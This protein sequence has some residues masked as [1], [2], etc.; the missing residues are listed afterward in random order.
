M[1]FS[2][3]TY[4]ARQDLCWTG[5]WDTFALGWQ[6][7][8]FEDVLYPWSVLEVSVGLLE[9]RDWVIGPQLCS[10]FREDCKKGVD[11]QNVFGDSEGGILTSHGGI[12]PANVCE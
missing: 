2:G 10:E 4:Q 3:R 5:R 9:R 8:V 6:E 7:T 1:D 11:E 12:D